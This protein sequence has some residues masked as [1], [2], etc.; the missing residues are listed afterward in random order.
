MRF[1]DLFGG[2]RKQCPQ[3]LTVAGIPLPRDLETRHLLFCGATGSGKSLAFS[4]LLE[5]VRARGQRA[6]INDPN[7]SYYSKFARQGDKILN[8]FDARGEGWTPFNEIRSAYDHTRLARAIIP[9]GAGAAAEWHQNAQS[10]YAA[11]SQR[12]AE[13]G[14]A[15]T[16]RLVYLLSQAPPEELRALLAGHPLAQYCDSANARFF[17]SVRAVLATYL[18]PLLWP[19]EGDF[20]VRRW[21]ENGDGC[22]F[23]THRDDMFLAVR[24]LISCWLDIAVSAALSLPP[25]LNR[26]LFFLLD[27][28]DSLEKLS[29]L[30]HGLTKLRQH[31][32]VVAAGLQALSQLEGNYGREDARTLLNN[33]GT[34]LILRAGDHHTAEAM[35]DHLGEQEVER[36]EA[37]ETHG[38]SDSRT[39]STR[40]AM[41]KIVLAS[42]VMNLRDRHGFLKL[43]GDYPACKIEVEIVDRPQRTEPFFDL[44]NPTNTPEKNGNTTTSGRDFQKTEIPHTPAS[45][46]RQQGREKE[47]F[48]GENQ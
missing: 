15:D 20:S 39:I 44:P 41:R 26:R 8:P 1:F 17:G 43:P 23:I 29:S 28:L 5:G 33:F 42:E 18:P 25:D 45:P 22:L 47:D 11:V 27:E 46:M 40:R 7:G 16:E 3:R 24:P 36:Q 6:I 4:E 32:G 21:V 48:P 31:G 35:S 14:E 2:G 37:S 30:K 9:D 12:L 13:R 34:W 38:E 10:L 19:A